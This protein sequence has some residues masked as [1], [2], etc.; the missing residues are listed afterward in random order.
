MSTKF[1]VII[2]G[3]GPTGL[4]AAHCFEKAG[5][6]YEILDRRA[7]LDENEGASAAIWPNS[8]RVFAQLGILDEALTSYFPGIKWKTNLLADGRVLGKSDV[9]AMPEV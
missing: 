8:A 4:T 2:V 5:I 9:M 6:D 3:G 1:K 7:S